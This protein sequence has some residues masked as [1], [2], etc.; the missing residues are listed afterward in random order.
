MRTLSEQLCTLPAGE[1]FR[2][3]ALRNLDLPGK[4]TEEEIREIRGVYS[5]SERQIGADYYLGFLSEWEAGEYDTYHEEETDPDVTRVLEEHTQK[6]LR[7]GRRL[8]EVEEIKAEYAAIL[9]DDLLRTESVRDLL[10]GLSDP[11]METIQGILCEEILQDEDG[12]YLLE[13][14]PDKA[15]LFDS[16]ERYGYALIRRVDAYDTD[17]DRIHYTGI[18]FAD[19]LLEQ[20]RKVYTD[21]VEAERNRNRILEDL[22]YIVQEYYTAVPVEFAHTVYRELRK[23]NPEAYPDWNLEEFEDS[24]NAWSCDSGST[25]YGIVAY[26]G[27][28]YF[29]NLTDDLE[30]E[31]EDEDIVSYTAYIIEQW[32]MPGSKAYIPDVEEMQSVLQYGYPADR[33][34]LWDLRE[35]I[36]EYYEEEQYLDGMG[37]NMFAMVMGDSDA[38]DYRRRNHYSMDMVE[39]KTDEMFSTI[40]TDLQGGIDAGSVYKEMK[41]LTLGTTE[42]FRRKFRRLLGKCEKCCPR[43]DLLGF[44]M[45]QVE[46]DGT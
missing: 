23:K 13:Y 27:K 14:D 16:V 9:A 5:A 39:E 25:L 34:P 17:D 18:S 31:Y 10:L 29:L 21:E 8:R 11:V 12:Y 22:E 6:S 2:L 35:L 4:W 20:I 30:A 43:S 19:D 41:K 7:I 1:L 38:D 33:K 46:A 36:K 42:S 3:A 32:N 26:Q 28:K 40:Y 37:G 15:H 24:V 45:D 44:S